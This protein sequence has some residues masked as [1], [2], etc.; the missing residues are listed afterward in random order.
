MHF[1]RDKPVFRGSEKSCFMG[2]TF[3][4]T[5]PAENGQSKVCSASDARYFGIMFVVSK[6]FDSGTSRSKNDQ[7]ST[8]PRN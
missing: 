6:Y 1:I 8:T 2:I 4:L 5:I 7:V 3:F